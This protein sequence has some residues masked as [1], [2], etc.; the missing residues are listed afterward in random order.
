MPLNKSKIKKIVLMA[1]MEDAAHRDIT[2][3]SFIPDRLKIEAKIIA[4]DSGVV[5]GVDIAK[6]VF[7]TFDKN[8]TFKENKRDGQAVKK[9]DAIASV[10]GGA[11]SILS[12]ER[13]ALNFLSYLSGIASDTREAVLKVKRKGIRILD[14]RKTTP[15]FREFEKYSVLMGSGKNHRFDLA[16][17]YLVKDNHLAV[18]KIARK[19]LNFSKRRDN[20]PF[21]IEVDSIEAL[22]DVL[23]FYP[24]IILLDNF[25]PKMIK[26]SIRLLKK[27]FPK[28]NERPF[29]ELSGGITLENI[30]DYAISG[31]DFIS[32]GALTHSPKALDVSLE[33]VNRLPR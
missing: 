13:V 6:T 22:K 5:C 4:K 30:S 17:Q 27:I 21:E 32:L 8:I 9:G 29:I 1:L 2:T 19:G 7:K 24:D 20:V 31:V 33:V 14:T 18:L 23:R 16:G 25:T 11:R 15:L 10:R 12:S 28:K 3:L 26:E